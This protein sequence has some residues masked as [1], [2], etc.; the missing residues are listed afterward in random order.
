MDVQRSS[1]IIKSRAE[2]RRPPDDRWRDRRR[3]AAKVALAALV[4]AAPAPLGDAVPGPGQVLTT[5]AFANYLDG[6]AATIRSLSDA[7]RALELATAYL[8]ALGEKAAPVVFWTPSRQLAFAKW[9]RDTYGH[10]PASIERRLDVVCA[11]F[12]DMCKV[13]LLRDPVTGREV[14]TAL[15][16]HAPEFI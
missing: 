3:Q 4:T 12:H 7:E 15:M 5:A 9:L 2:R 13:R 14:E 8:V 16:S 10:A 6:H 11:A 1:K